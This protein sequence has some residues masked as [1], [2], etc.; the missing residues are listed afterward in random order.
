MPACMEVEMDAKR[1]VLLLTAAILAAG[2]AM[3]VI[4]SKQ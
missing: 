2:I 4:V 3:F 1:L